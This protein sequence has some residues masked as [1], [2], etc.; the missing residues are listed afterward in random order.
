V[1]VLYVSLAGQLLMQ[2]EQYI[3]HKTI[4]ASGN[5]AATSSYKPLSYWTLGYNK[6][7]RAYDSIKIVHYVALG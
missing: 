4:G 5:L 1:K 3:N 2:T 6:P 7:L